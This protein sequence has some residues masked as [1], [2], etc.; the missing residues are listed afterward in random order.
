MKV[1]E[2]SFFYCYAFTLSVLEYSLKSKIPAGIGL[3]FQNLCMAKAAPN[4]E[5]C[6]NDELKTSIPG[7]AFA[8]KFI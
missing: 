4:A 6:G 7:K 2:H 8:S 5:A 3:E 1:L